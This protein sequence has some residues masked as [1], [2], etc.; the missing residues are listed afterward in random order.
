MQKRPRCRCQTGR[1]AA[2]AITVATMSVAAAVLVLTAGE[3]IAEEMASSGSLSFFADAQDAHI[4]LD[5][6]NADPEIA[7]IVPDGPRL[8][9]PDKLTP[10]APP[11]GDR[12][13]WTVIKVTFCHGQDYWQRWRA[14]RPVDG[15]GDEEQTLWHISAGPLVSSGGREWRPIPDPWAGWTS[16]HPVCR[17]NLMAPATIRLNLVTRHTAYTPEER[18]T[19]RMLNAYWINGDQ[20]VASDFQWSG[21]SVQPGGSAATARWVASLEDWFNRNAVALHDRGGTQVFWAFPSALQRLK[22][23][24]P[25]Y[26]RNFDLDES[27]RDGR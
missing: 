20:L 22:S 19:L 25:Y 17:P 4:L 1:A 24:I 13:H 8:P 12:Q 6:L 10:V 23:G 9:P 3:G 2:M 11:P 14:T 26:A 27:I 7:F 5:R 16:E 21:G 18:S 15:L